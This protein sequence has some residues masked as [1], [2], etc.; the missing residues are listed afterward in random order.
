MTVLK[1][2][3]PLKISG[4]GIEDKKSSKRKRGKKHRKGKQNG[5]KS[6]EDEMVTVKHKVEIHTEELPDGAVSTGDEDVSSFVSFVVWLIH[7]EAQNNT[8]GLAKM[9]G[10]NTPVYTVYPS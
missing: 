5:E 4:L 8:V 10:V 3:I 7:C 6:S 9:C 1:L 2:D